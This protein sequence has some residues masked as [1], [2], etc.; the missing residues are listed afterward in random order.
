[1]GVPLNAPNKQHRQI[2]PDLS[3]VVEKDPGVRNEGGTEDREAF[4]EPPP[5]APA[6][7][8]SE[9]GT[10]ENAQDA[11]QSGRSRGEC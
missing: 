5:E 4:P 11:V 1:M 6:E 2:S 7:H 3:S 10:G 9:G 8:P